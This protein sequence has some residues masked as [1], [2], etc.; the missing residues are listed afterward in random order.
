MDFALWGNLMDDEKLID[1]E[2]ETDPTDD[3]LLYLVNDPDGDGEDVK[4]QLSNIRLLS[5]LEAVELSEWL[6]NVTL[7][8]NGVTTLPQLVLT[9]SA[10]AIEAIEGG[11]FYNSVD[12]A[13]YVCTDI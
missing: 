2:E 9:P 6:D 1:L 12:K 4:V 10:A 13:V 8:S 5:Q 11:I 3:A 7:G